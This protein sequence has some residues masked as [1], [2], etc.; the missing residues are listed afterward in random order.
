MVVFP[1]SVFLFLINFI[2]G[3]PMLSL[4]YK[5][6]TSNFISGKSATC[7]IEKYL[8]PLE[9]TFFLNYFKKAS[10]GLSTEFFFMI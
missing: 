1:L 3:K 9:N 10:F 4:K 8:F 5:S 7:I 2:L 6:N